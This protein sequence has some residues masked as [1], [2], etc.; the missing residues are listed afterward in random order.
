MRIAMNEKA[1]CSEDQI[2]SGTNMSKL[3]S[4]RV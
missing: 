1:I 3:W 4:R 2:A